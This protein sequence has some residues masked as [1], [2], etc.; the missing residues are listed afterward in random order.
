MLKPSRHCP[1]PQKRNLNSSA[2]PHM[3]HFLLPHPLT[4]YHCP[5]GLLAV[6]G[7]TQLPLPCD[8]CPFSSLSWTLSPGSHT[9]NSLCP[10]RKTPLSPKQ[11]A[12]HSGQ[13][14][15]SRHWLYS[16]RHDSVCI[17]PFFMICL[18]NRYRKVGTCPFRSHPQCLKQCPAHSRNSIYLYERE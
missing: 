5:T 18:P 10:L 12:C 3:T 11:R 16:I 8:L 9:A 2:V 15:S 14:L 13:Y 7:A 6:P 4:S 17:R 1:C